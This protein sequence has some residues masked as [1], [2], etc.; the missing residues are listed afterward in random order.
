MGW[1]HPL[2]TFVCKGLCRGP[3]SRLRTWGKLLLELLA[4]GAGPL[5]LAAERLFL[6]KGAT[7]T[8]R[9]ICSAILGDCVAQRIGSHTGMDVCY[10]ACLCKLHIAWPLKSL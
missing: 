7:T 5:S 8:S 9:K 4:E 1:E 2:S 6:S 3:G 10:F